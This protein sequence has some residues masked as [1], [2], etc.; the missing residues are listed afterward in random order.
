M[1]RFVGAFLTGS[2]LLFTASCSSKSSDDASKQAA[3]SAANSYDV[4]QKKA[5]SF[6]PSIG[7]PGGEIILSSFSDPK[8]FNPITSTETSTS[9]F[10]NLMYEGLTAVDGVTLEVEPALAE[11]WEISED[12]L[13]WTF[14]MRPGVVWS[15]GV[16]IS[17]YDVEFTFNDLIYNMDISPNS[18]RDI[19][20]FEGKHMKVEAVD[21]S[22]V[23]F[24]L[25]IP[26]APFLRSMGQEILPKHKYA[27]MVRNKTFSTA[28][29]IRT[30]PK[31]MVI[32][33]PW[34]LE[35]YVSSQK[36]VLKRNPRYWK[37]DAEGNQL[38]YLDKL[39]YL[40]VS[41]QNAQL[42]KFKQG[43]I[44]FLAA[45][46][47]DYP[48]L[49]KDENSGYTVYRLGPAT[50][51][52]F[53]FFNQVLD[54]DPKTAKP[55][56]DPVKSKWFR[57]TNFR[58][59]VAHAIDKEGMINVV[60]NGLGYPQRSSM[61]P[62]EGYFYNPDVPQY[63]Y[64]P[65]RAL[66]ILEKEGFTDKNGDGFLEDEDGN[67]VEFSLVTNSGNNNRIK[68]A[69]MIRKDLQDLGMKIHFQQLEF[70]S[71][72][73]KMDNPPFEY[74]AILLA[75][76]GGVEPHFG[77][78]V[79][80]SSGTLHMWY[81]R[82]KKPSTEWEARI[83]SIFEVG[84]RELDREKRKKLYDEWQHIAADNLPL[85]YT[86]LPERIH[87]LWDKYENV[88]PSTNGGLLHNLEYIYMK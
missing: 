27:A 66:E 34:M 71:L 20:T 40:L 63:P 58:K 68:I 48:G 31:D 6:E 29:D 85:I 62:A 25:P 82:Q 86:V 2:L 49:K 84:G 37:K 57:N 3:S 21:S 30:K 60:M 39:I 41:D 79:W 65:K 70:N 46:G 53:I 69:E 9:E 15:D 87:C 61:T 83:D 13:T 59:A 16:P 44:D 45:R 74:D 12:G 8:S 10:T 50:G 14:Y 81:P 52:S 26:F 32:N 75:L 19:F 47:E 67:T 24:T 55:Y 43:E 80:H 18:A 5:E 77:K 1:N 17:A 72:I 88:N 76:T 51:S 28:L 33:G 78:N 56:V 54:K 7:K 23:Q 35:S 11:R 22:K 73:Q 4:L 64:D 38:P 42:L 36:V